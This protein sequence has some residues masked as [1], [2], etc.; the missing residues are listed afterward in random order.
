MSKKITFII[1][2]KKEILVENGSDENFSPEETLL[3]LEKIFEAMARTY[4]YN[5]DYIVD[6]YN[7]IITNAQFSAN[8]AI[9]KIY[10]DKEWGNY[11]Q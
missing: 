9:L 10:K 4:Y 6:A 7:K 8:K 3:I 1:N 5:K 11:E 2:D